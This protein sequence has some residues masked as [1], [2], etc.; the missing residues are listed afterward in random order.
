M[1]KLYL[2]LQREARGWEEA[3]K[4]KEGE[5]TKRGMEGNGG[6]L[7]PPLPIRYATGSGD[8]TWLAD[9]LTSK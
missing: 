1:G 8:L 6:R 5:G 2:L 7:L 9:F 4:G 3:K